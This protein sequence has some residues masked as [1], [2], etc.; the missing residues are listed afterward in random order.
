MSLFD[1]ICSAGFD[2]E[3]RMVWAREFIRAWL[4]T[5]ELRCT[6]GLSLDSLTD[7][8]NHWIRKSVDFNQPYPIVSSED[9][10]EAGTQILDVEVLPK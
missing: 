1:D 7:Q 6:A 9:V 3:W 2:K 4:A 10:K 8:A 5:P